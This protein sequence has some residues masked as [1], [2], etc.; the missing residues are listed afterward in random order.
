MIM[1][2]FA[3]AEIRFSIACTC[4]SLSPSCLPAKVCSCTPACCA[5]CV[6]PAFILTKNGLV[7][8]LVTRPTIACSPDAPPVAPDPP[9]PDDPPPPHAASTREAVRPVAITAARRPLGKTGSALVRPLA[10]VDR[11]ASG[12]GQLGEWTTL[13]AEREARHTG[14]QARIRAGGITVP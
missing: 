1:K 2:P 12:M 3:P 7:S 13:S 9:E 11:E 10:F 6:A 14:G 4:A 8:V 5:A